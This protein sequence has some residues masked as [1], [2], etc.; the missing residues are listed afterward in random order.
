MIKLNKTMKLL[1]A[2]SVLLFSFSQI[3]MAEEDAALIA[4][5]S[6]CHIEN[7]DTA[8][9]PKIWGQK[10][11]KLITMMK[12]F[13]KNTIEN[14]IMHRIMKGYNDKEIREMAKLISKKEG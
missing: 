2:I 8:S 1:I 14:T 5:C 6:S 13:Q 4:P 7:S 11:S 10:K 3:T 12:S 9:M